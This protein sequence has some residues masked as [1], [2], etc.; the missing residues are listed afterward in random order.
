MKRIAVWVGNGKIYIASDEELEVAFADR[1]GEYIAV[2]E[3]RPDRLQQI[4]LEHQTQ[5]AGSVNGDT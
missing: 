2:V 1:D 3:P 4:F 5:T